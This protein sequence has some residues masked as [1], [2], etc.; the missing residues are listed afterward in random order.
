MCPQA[1]I[2]ATSCDIPCSS[3]KKPIDTIIEQCDTPQE[4]LRARIETL[5]QQRKKQ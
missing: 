5:Q 2:S 1:T 3:E 4:K